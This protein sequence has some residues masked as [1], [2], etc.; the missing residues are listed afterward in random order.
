MNRYFLIFQIFIR[1]SALSAKVTDLNL[2]HSLEYRDVYYFKLEGQTILGI[3]LAWY[4][5]NILTANLTKTT[6]T[7][8]LCQVL[9][10]FWPL[11]C[12]N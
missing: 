3:N 8:E 2:D 6:E 9:K 4:T 7:S 1:L 10:E 11:L 5:R 12:V